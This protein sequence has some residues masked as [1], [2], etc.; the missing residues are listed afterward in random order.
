LEPPCAW[1][2]W[3]L[4]LLLGVW[5]TSSGA[6]WQDDLAIVRDL[7]LSP[8]GSEGA[9]SSVLAQLFAL[10]PVGSRCLRVG[11]VGVSALAVCSALS[12]S[13][14][15]ELLDARRA[16]GA[17]PLLALV[18]SQLWALSPLV[19]HDTSAPGS[20][21]LGLLTILCGVGLLRRDGADARLVPLAGALLG[22]SWGESHSAAVV[23][24]AVLLTHWWLAADPSPAG[25]LETPGAVREETSEAELPWLR[26][27][28]CFA[29]AAGSC[30]LV[31][32]LRSW[33][34]HAWLD[35]GLSALPSEPPL[36]TGSL[37]RGWIDSARQALAPPL[38][39][40]GA[41]AVL[42]ALAGVLIGFGRR[43]SR[44]RL[45]PW[46][47][48]T[49]AGLLGPFA[50]A[51]QSTALALC[52]LCASVGATAFVAVALQTALAWLWS[53]PVPFA[54][55]ASVLSVSFALTLVLQRVES[56]VPSAGPSPAELA[57]DAWTEEALG[58]LPEQSVLLVQ[59]PALALR[60]W[61][62]QLQGLR[63]DVVL[64]PLAL[65]QR[66]SVRE[67]LLRRAPELK[68]LLRQLAV[69]GK[70]DE[71]VLGR[72]AD[73][74][75]LF[76][77]LDPRWDTRLLEH[78]TPDALWLGFAPHALGRSDRTAGV[79]RARAAL[80][81]L[82]A[83]PELAGAF[84]ARTRQVLAGQAGQQALAL[85][86][87]GEVKP[88]ERVLR[89]LRRIQPRDPLA[90]ELTARLQR[91]TG[92]VAV[93]ELLALVAPEPAPGLR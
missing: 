53:N 84:D 64:V 68:P 67:R 36:G 2:A 59:N 57:S 14:L 74:R 16:F 9:L 46:A 7:G 89:S 86:V 58:R 1:L 92:R 71:Y 69:N 48:L 93:N 24:L 85:A 32:W 47:T 81:R 42:L 25:A 41:L 66:G 21:A 15:R 23:L 63:P 62:A 22:L 77:E 10:A 72:L 50:L 49:L 18:G 33:A 8:A 29:L 12:Y 51:G 61:S 75:P 35:L 87:L 56:A 39:R 44:Q 76:V 4:P 40:L 19:L 90:L 55:P 54:R 88:A 26:F 65:L 6:R 13:L 73:A 78:L 31:P 79:S 20:A 82:L 60:L 91:G 27:L 5:S 3:L 17:N 38:E 45:V 28:L 52:A 70:P 34:S 83:D 30:A 80:A 43:V 11:L 37:G